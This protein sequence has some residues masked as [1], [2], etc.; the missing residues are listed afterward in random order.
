MTIS[1]SAGIISSASLQWFYLFKVK[2]I[3]QWELSQ[4]VSGAAKF[5]IPDQ[6]TEARGLSLWTAKC[7]AEVIAWT[8]CISCLE[9]S[10]SNW[11][12]VLWWSWRV[13][14]HVSNQSMG[15]S[16]QKLARGLLGSASE[17]VSE[18]TGSALGVR[19]GTAMTPTYTTITNTR[20]VEFHPYIIFITEVLS[21]L[22]QPDVSFSAFKKNVCLC[23]LG[24]FAL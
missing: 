24:K 2:S 7:A 21:I 5:S 15:S 9:S 17:L 18:C 3:L 12:N 1:A 11:W 4:R 13:N 14:S 23:L 22:P 20:E 6:H 10:C 8:L 19:M 16:Q